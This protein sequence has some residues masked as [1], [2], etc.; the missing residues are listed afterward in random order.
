MVR[1]LAK[2]ARV[3]NCGGDRPAFVDVRT[4]DENRLGAARINSREIM[5]PI[6]MPAT[7]TSECH[8]S[9]SNSSN[10]SCAICD[11]LT[12]VGWEKYK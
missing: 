9:A 5:P 6:E 7:F 11:V 10:A 3:T 12:C 1:T 8:P 2:K 4:K